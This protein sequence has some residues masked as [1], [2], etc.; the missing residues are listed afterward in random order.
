[1]FHP[2]PT[3]VINLKERTD[4]RSHIELQFETR[5]E[6]SLHFVDAVK[7]NI[8][9]IGL[10]ETIKHII[11]NVENST[12]D[13]IILCEDDHVFTDAYI[14]KNFIRELNM[15]R[16]LGA[17][18]LVGGP[19]YVNGTL[20]ISN[21][22]FWVQK[23]TGT[24]FIMVFRQFFNKILEANFQDEDCADGKIC[25]LSQQIFFTYPF[26]SI[27]KDFGYSDAT[28]KN[29]QIGIINKLYHDCLESILLS[30]LVRKHY[31]S[32]P[33]TQ[34]P[35]DDFLEGICISTF[36]IC[37][38]NRSQNRIHIEDQFKGRTEFS[39]I[40]VNECIQ[41]NGEV[42]LGMTIQ[43]IIQKAIDNDDDVIIIVEDNHVFT[44]AY[45][46]KYLFLNIYEA[47]QQ[48]ADCLSGGS[49]GFG[50]SLPI[51]ENRFWINS[52]LSFQFIVI[53]RSFYS[54]ILLESF[55][56]CIDVYTQISDMT[57]SK[58]ILFPFISVKKG[59]TSSYENSSESKKNNNINKLFI[60]SENRLK[61]FQ[62]V[63]LKYGKSSSF[64]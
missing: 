8:G 15:A 25:E 29:N 53:Y 21:N 62:K 17:D 51:T 35:P 43:K 60:E 50:L 49:S 13:Y 64:H 31:C 54:K 33:K 46:K 4:R 12:C 14:Y 36:V 16:G 58:I 45:S 7:H 32:L 38:H 23:F 26:I 52:L 5:N 34:K 37:S 2:I 11:Q 10:W 56:D 41:P 55:D 22:L 6:F 27:Q 44:N 47:Y 61:S 39:P 30:E 9:A 40:F 20:P 19:S 18:I 59:M 28:A 48:G 42:S 24:Q 63:Y 3:Y 1:M 57:S